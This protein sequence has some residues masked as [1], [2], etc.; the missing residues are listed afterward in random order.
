MKKQKKKELQII[1]EKQKKLENN[2]RKDSLQTVERL[3][4]KYET[5]YTGL[6][7]E[8]VEEKA[9]EFGKNTIEEK[10]NHPVINR[11]K[12][13][14]IN[15][16][17]IVLIAVA[18]I[19][20]ITDVIIPE[21]PD[22][23][24][25]VLVSAAV[26]ISGVI[27]FS[28]QA[29]SDNAARQLKNMISNKIDVIR[30]G[31]VTEITV[32]EVVPGDI[33]KLASGDMIPADVRFIEAKDLFIDQ[34]ALTGESVPVE[35]Y[36]TA[37][38]CEN[39]T[40]IADIGFMGTDVVS[41][42]A[43]ALV[44]TTGSNTYFGNMAKSLEGINQQNSFEQGVN[45]ISM[46]LIRFMGI[47]LPV[48]LVINLFTKND[49]QESILFAVTIAVGLTPEMLPVIMTST[50]A[51]GAVA[52]SKKKTVVKK[53]SAIQTFGQMD[54]L[55]T[56]KTGTLTEDQVV[57]EKYMDPEGHESERILR[58][59]FLNSYYQTGL[60]NLIDVAIIARA[61][62][63][64]L[65]YLKTE[66]T[67]IDEIPF[68]FVRRRMSVV[69]QDSKGK[70]QLIT[71]GAVDETLECCKY[72]ESSE[73]IVELTEERRKAAYD[74]YEKYNQDGLRILAVAQKNDILDIETFKVSDES[75][76]VLLGFIGFLDPPKESAKQ[77]IEAL[78]M[79]GVE[80]VVLT[81]DSQGVAIN[82]CEKVGIDPSNAI[83]GMQ[84]D[85]YSDEQLKGMLENCHLLS[86][87]S[88]VQKQRVV[89][90]F[91]ENGHT[92]GYL[93]D[94]INDSPALKQA[95]VGISVD[96]A[97]DIAKETADIILLE[98]DLMVLEE[99]VVNGRK[100]FTNV[101]KYIKMAT[102]GNFGN[103]LSVIIASLFL[104][105]LPLLPIHIL[106]Q[107]LLNDLAQIGM[108]FDNVDEDY[109]QKPKKWD[110][111]DIKKF[112]FVFGPISTVLDVCCFLILWFVFE[113]N[114]LELSNYFQS[115]WFVFGILSQTLIIH[116]I[117][118]DK[119]PFV[120]SKSSPELMISTGAVVLLTL[121]ITFTKIAPLFQLSM[122]PARYLI[123]LL[124][125]LIMYVLAIG[126]YKRIYRK[127]TGTWL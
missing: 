116:A 64:G 118:T 25:F 76:M 48:I 110:T 39:I 65:N 31:K 1:A 4:G 96:T 86:K 55:C 98:K 82:V 84:I 108:P 71:K 66:Y 26:I 104:P 36:A 119:I 19:T 80:T 123:Y 126:V 47:L 32:E 7:L 18:I 105:F 124:V 112:M 90:L 21:R 6:T 72:M 107:N 75:N 68:D 114:T 17:N 40:D 101:L 38:R 9:D 41:G 8:D 51:K 12:E 42:S 44:L 125:L 61:E 16:F 93:G 46:L 106:L 58:H 95:D 115:G 59:S 60:K 57:L 5:D 29:K 20:L 3:L 88:P 127:N 34:A 53:L 22:F 70:K 85:N 49:I 67:R 15:P 117:R 111:N 35:K 73:G 69:L 23:S 100:T 77:A 91:Q 45:S 14:V 11:I 27:S 50:L 99:G 2:L 113:Y 109:I 120:Y 30:E 81:G 121:T 94:G 63:Q 83:D 37:T 56:D 92:V 103:A 43:L 24:T 62:K 102:S 54:L 13:A 87:L 89:R 10:E 97:V 78:Q 28:Q 79:H 33:V 122:L 74:I 52:M